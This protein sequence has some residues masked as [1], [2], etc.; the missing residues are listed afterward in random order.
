LAETAVGAVMTHPCRN[1]AP[2]LSS[3]IGHVR[4]S[5]PR[6]EETGSLR[7]ETVSTEAGAAACGS[8]LR[9][10][11]M[12]RRYGDPRARDDQLRLGVAPV[13]WRGASCASAD[14][15]PLFLLGP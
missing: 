3:G 2:C 14:A 8:G 13:P 6:D 4:H 9:R 10:M 1:D 7:Q 15:E 11:V 12:R 5:A